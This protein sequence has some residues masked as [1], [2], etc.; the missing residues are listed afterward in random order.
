M[1]GDKIVVG[2][3]KYLD[4]TLK[5]IHFAKEEGKTYKVYSPVPVHQIEEATSEKRSPVALVT[6]TGALTG[7]T[8]G[9]GLCIL[10]NLDWPIRVSA[11]DI[12]ALPAFVPVGYECTIL[13][14]AIFTLLGLFHLCR[15]PDIF[16]APGYDPRFSQDKFGVV[17]GCNGNEIE[18]VS[19]KLKSCGAEEVTVGDGL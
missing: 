4:D 19:S 7:I 8:F 13:F 9:F 18:T 11:K 14:G 16:R 6:G 5:A 15:V 17:V 3:F 1:S 10:C 2:V 12:V